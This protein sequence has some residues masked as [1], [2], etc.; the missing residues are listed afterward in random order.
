MLRHE[1]TVP[2]ADRQ[3]AQHG[4]HRL[5]H[6]AAAREGTPSLQI[7]V[8]ETRVAA[9]IKAKAVRERVSLAASPVKPMNITSMADLIALLDVPTEEAKSG[10][11]DRSV[12]ICLK[13]AHK[14][15]D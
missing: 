8:L 7:R 4:D 10:S 15:W 6:R 2:D 9:V 14:V 11:R 13:E 1:G 12:M 5:E 3:L